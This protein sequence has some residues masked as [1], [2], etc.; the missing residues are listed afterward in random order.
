ME[1]RFPSS[2]CPGGDITKWVMVTIRTTTKASHKQQD[3]VSDPECK[4]F[5]ASGRGLANVNIL[6]H[7][8]LSPFFFY[9]LVL[10]FLLPFLVASFSSTVSIF[11][12]P[13]FCPIGSWFVLNMVES[14][15]CHSFM[16]TFSSSRFVFFSHVLGHPCY[17]HHYGKEK[18]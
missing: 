13:T 17:H 14:K 10:L 1:P 2:H 12:S 15:V 4:H 8:D 6:N 5:P 3:C 16:V 11:H 18:C 9:K 7:C